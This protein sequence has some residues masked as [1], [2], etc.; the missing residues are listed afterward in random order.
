MSWRE[1]AKKV[2]ALE[3]V[4]HVRDGFVLGL[5]SGSTV[6]Y[7]IKEI[8]KRV[9]KGKLRVKGVPTSHQAFLLALECGVPVATLNEYPKLDLTIDGADQVDKNLNLIKGL[10]GA[11]TREKIV[12]SVS[13]QFIIVVDETKVVSKLGVDCPVP[14]EVLPFA[15]PTVMLKLRELKG[16]PQLRVGVGKVGPVVTDN[17]NFVVDVK[18]NSIDDLKKLDVSLKLIPGIVETGLFVGM[19]DMIYV[20]KRV[21]VEMLC[22]SK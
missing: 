14:V 20:G 11:L 17:G 4:K 1:K 13:K 15:L 2:A 18:F 5:G 9:K 22:K 3:A 19:A 7:A 6:A 10:G 12:A 16:K 8:G 21:G